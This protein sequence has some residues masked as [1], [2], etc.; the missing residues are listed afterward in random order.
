MQFGLSQSQFATLM[1]S[2]LINVNSQTNQNFDA[3]E[4]F[5]KLTRESELSF[6]DFAEYIIDRDL[7]KT[8]ESH[9]AKKIVDKLHLNSIQANS[10]S[11]GQTDTD[12]FNVQLDVIDEFSEEAYIEVMFKGDFEHKKDLSFSKHDSLVLNTSAKKRFSQHILDIDK[13]EEL[14]EKEDL[15]LDIAEIRSKGDADLIENTSGILAPTEVQA[16]ELDAS[17]ADVCKKHCNRLPVGDQ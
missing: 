13:Y 3:I 5:G 1:E 2:A 11:L 17:L 8:V 6:L 10:S 12:Q 14:E 9:V 16:F 15:N 7:N 4:V